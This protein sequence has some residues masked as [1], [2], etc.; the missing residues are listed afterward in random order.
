MDRPTEHL[1]AALR[2]LVHAVSVMPDG[3][4]RRRLAVTALEVYSRAIEDDGHCYLSAEDAHMMRAAAVF[5][6]EARAVDRYL[7]TLDAEP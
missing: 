6:V 4:P 5:P 7:S 1:R 3:F 2:E